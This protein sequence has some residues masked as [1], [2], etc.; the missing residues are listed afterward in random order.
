MPACPPVT[1]ETVVHLKDVARLTWRQ[2]TART[3][4]SN[5]TARRWYQWW[6]KEGRTSPKKPPGRPRTVRTKSNISKVKQFTLNKKGKS[7]RKMA[8]K[9][10]G[11]GSKST[12]HRILR[13]DLKLKAVKR[14]RKVKLTAAHKA[15]R[16]ATAQF[17]V[18]N[19]VTIK[20]VVYT[21]EK[22][23]LLNPKPGR[24]DFVWTNDSHAP[25]TYQEISKY[26]RGAVEVWG[27]ITYY[28]AIDLVF[29]ERPVVQR[30]KKKFTAEDYREKILKVKVPEISRLFEQNGI[31]NWWFQQDGDS[32]HTAKATQKWL[33]ENVPHFTTKDQWP[34]NS[35]DLNLIENL[36]S[37]LDRK[38]HARRAR[39]LQ[40]LKKVIKDEWK[41]LSLETIQNLYD[42]YPNRLQQIIERNGDMSD[43]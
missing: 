9:L 7:I 29:I 30:Q 3:K 4:V 2:I 32:K 23:F 35:P 22:R 11:V 43:Y 6:H 33:Q 15:H 20:D 38:V 12:I 31:S 42:S 34:A 26:N 39:T 8:K 19:G 28:G 18:S 41:K 16:L 37:I 27:A 5:R 21:D 1:A 40:G 13:Q 17:Q 24:S 36:W 10:N 25:V 14:K